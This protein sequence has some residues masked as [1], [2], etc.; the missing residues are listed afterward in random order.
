VRTKGKIT[1]WDDGKGY[2]FIAPLAGGGRRFVHVKAFANRA[3]RPA[4]GDIVTYTL[5][6]DA[7]GRPCAED[8]A[9]AG[10]PSAAKPKTRTGALSQVIAAVFLL[11]VCAAA[12]L[13]ALPPAVPAIYLALSLATGVAY[14]LDKLA[15]ER[16]GWRT[17]ERTLHVLALA[18]G[19][20]GALIAQGRLRHKTRKQPFRTIFR[21]TVLLNCAA[22]AW[23]FTPEGASAWRSIVLA[24]T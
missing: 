9:I 8:V 3:R 18:G 6:T 4:V 24:I 14:V 21:V 22:L 7:R 11:L 16:G 10:V 23:L 2:G 20:P 1:T 19:W 13:S 17:S 12:F 5:S 15:A